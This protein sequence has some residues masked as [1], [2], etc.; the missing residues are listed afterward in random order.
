MVNDIL[1]MRAT[2]LKLYG[3]L[4]NWNTVRDADWLEPLLKWEEIERSKRGLES[5]LAS[6]HL[7]RFKPFTEFDWNWPKKCDREMLEELMLLTFMEKASNIIFSGPCGVGKTMFAKNIAHQAVIRGHTALVVTAG[8]MLTDLNK[9]PNDNML[10]RRM[11]HYVR[12]SLLVID[13]VGYFSYSNRH[14]DLLFEIVSSRYEEK[15]TVITTNCPFSEWNKMFPNAACVVSLIDRLVHNSEM[16][17]IE[18]DSYRLKEAERKNAQRLLSFSN[19][20]KSASS[21]LAKGKNKKEEAT[22]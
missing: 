11:K 7:K 12:P 17:S 13:E 2:A 6:A 22:T 4:A 15:S 9:Q 14:A 20:E 21:K 1:Q 18:G 19:K 16:V 5:R 10:E 3:I 8:K